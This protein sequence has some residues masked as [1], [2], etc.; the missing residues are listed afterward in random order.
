[1]LA[2]TFSQTTALI[3]AIVWPFVVV[4]ALIFYRRELSV[5]LAKLGGRISRVSFGG[6]SVEFIPASEAPATDVSAVTEFIDASTTAGAVASDAGPS[7]QL[8]IHSTGADFVKIDLRSGRAW[9]TSRLYI[10]SVIFSETAQVKRIAF[11]QTS[12]A[13]VETFV[14]LANPLDAADRLGSRF[15]WFCY[16]LADAERQ[17]TDYQLSGSIDLARPFTDQEWASKVAERYLIHPLIRAAA[18]AGAARQ[19]ASE[20]VY[21]EG[22]PPTPQPGIVV[23]YNVP[24]PTPE[25]PVINGI[26]P[27]SGSPTGG[28]AVS[29]TGRGFGGVKE[30]R[31]GDSLAA[32]SSVTVTEIMA[33]SPPGHGN[34]PIRVKT[35]AGSS[36]ATDDW[37]TI[38]SS[39]SAH[40]EHA[41]WIR[42]GRHLRS[43][44]G[45]ALDTSCI[46]EAPDAKPGDLRDQVLQERGD[47][48]A[49]V[50]PDNRFLR[51]IDRRASVEHLRKEVLN[52][53]PAL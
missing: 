46:I 41:A 37:V 19:A 50:G 21:I 32:I 36:S 44:L 48:V 12:D 20:F 23:P 53:R 24:P 38:S 5:F 14:G 30:V 27:S 33:F 10:F 35:P 22:Q 39:G 52:T 25:L 31:F 9:L 16:A 47:F 7:L 1:M 42:D 26:A 11:V 40:D 3:N 6:A 43:L 17:T 34:V 29:I 8:A 49:I 4:V 18:H 51:L 45:D 28:M 15:H 13:G 2:D